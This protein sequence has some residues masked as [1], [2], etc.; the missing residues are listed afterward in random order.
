MNRDWYMDYAEHAVRVINIETRRLELRG[1]ITKN[2]HHILIGEEGGSGGGA[3][4]S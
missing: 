1:W 4:G 2:G 3:R